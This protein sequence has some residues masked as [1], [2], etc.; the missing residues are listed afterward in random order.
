[1]LISVPHHPDVEGASVVPSSSL[2]VAALHQCQVS[3]NG[4]A[5]CSDSNGSVPFQL[6][7]NSLAS[8]TAA[9]QEDK[10][11]QHLISELDIIGWQRIENVTADLQSFCVRSMCGKHVLKCCIPAGY[12]A[13]VP[14]YEANLPVPLQATAQKV[15]ET[16]GEW[17][18]QLL[19]LAPFF[20]V[21]EELDNSVLVLDPQTPEPHHTHRRLMFENQVCVVVTMCPTSALAPPHCH[22]IGASDLTAPL[23]ARLTDLYQRWDSN[24]GLVHNLEVLLQG[25]LVRRGSCIPN[26]LLTSSSGACEEADCVMC[27]SFQSEDGELPD[28]VCDHCRHSMH[29]SCLYRVPPLNAPLL[30]LPVAERSGGQSTEHATHLRRLPL[31]LQPDLLQSSC[32]SSLSTCFTPWV[33]KILRAGIS[34]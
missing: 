24:E 28:L 18:R 1:M 6:L 19:Q 17:D 15:S 3:T 5:P 7:E 20:C 34:I 27:Y 9:T 23:H 12:P 11:W 4:K 33:P 16:V 10:D 13:A 21:L 22:F 30:P 2:F 29:H 26:T 31:L 14:S 8:E 25:R 32:L